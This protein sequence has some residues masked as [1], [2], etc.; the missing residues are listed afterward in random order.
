MLLILVASYRLVDNDGASG[1]IHAQK[2]E[3]SQI[4][5]HDDHGIYIVQ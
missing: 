2:L 4:K 3:G 1:C 5:M